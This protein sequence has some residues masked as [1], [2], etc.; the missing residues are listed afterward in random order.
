VVALRHWLGR[1][2]GQDAILYGRLR[3]LRD[4][5]PG[6]AKTTIQLLHGFTEVQTAQPELYEV[7]IDLVKHDKLAIRGL[8]HWHLQR[9]APLVKVEFNP[10]SDKEEW[11]KAAA[12]WKKEI[13]RGKLP[14]T[15]KDKE[16][17]TET[18]EK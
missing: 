18:R 10:A 14:P 12:A 3:K 15:L 2:P 13:P 17:E 11:Q 9:L 8:A 5:S 1:G 4:Y 6:E 16:K 7:L